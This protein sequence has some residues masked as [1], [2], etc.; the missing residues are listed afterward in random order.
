MT[1]KVAACWAARPR[2]KRDSDLF[3]LFMMGTGSR[4]AQKALKF[5]AFRNHRKQSLYLGLSVGPDA[6]I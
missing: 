1:K 5:S 4:D 2:L 6:Q 3:G